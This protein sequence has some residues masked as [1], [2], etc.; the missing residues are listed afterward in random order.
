MK[1]CL[2]VQIIFN[3][4]TLKS[5]KLRMKMIKWADVSQFH[6]SQGYFTLVINSEVN[7]F[8]K[9]YKLWLG[10]SFIIIITVYSVELSWEPNLLINSGWKS[11]GDQELLKTINYFQQCMERKAKANIL[12]NYLTNCYYNL[13]MF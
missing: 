4:Q 2:H 6:I 13:D 1:Q 11:N 3:H 8:V 9:I 7:R 5:Y 10:F 12:L